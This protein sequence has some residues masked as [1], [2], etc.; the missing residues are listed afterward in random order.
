MNRRHSLPAEVYA[1]VEQTPATVLLE[2]RAQNYSEGNKKPW[3][4]LFTVPL[5]VCAAYSAA[6]VP[7][8]F[9]AIESAVAAGRCA[10]GFFTYECGTF[11][12]P[13]AT[14]HAPRA[15]QPLA[16]FG[17]YERGYAFDHDGGTFVD[18]EPPELERLRAGASRSTEPEA[19]IDADF[20]LTQPEYIRR[21]AAIH[22][23]IRAGDVYQLNFTAPFRVNAAGSP[24]ALYA[25]LRTRQPVD[26]G[27]FI[28]WE[29]GQHI[30]SFSP[31]LFF[32]I[33]SE[34][35]VRR[36]VTRPMKGTAQR[37]RTTLED[38]EIADWLRNDPKNR[39]ENV[40]I[41]DMLRNDLGRIA[42]FGTVRVEDL[43]AVERY[44]TLWQ[45]TSTVTGE[46]RPEIDFHGIFRA[47]FPSGSITGAPKVR[48]MQLLAELEGRPRGVYTGAIGFFSS[49]Q[50]IFNVAI[51]TLEL[52]EGRGVFGVG[53]GV[54]IDSNPADEF[55]ECQL[56]AE[57]LTGPAHRTKDRFFVSQPDELFLIETMLWNG[58][59]PFL[60]L[61]L[62]RLADSADYFGFACDRAAV[63]AALVQHAQQFSSDFPR[64]V[65][66]LMI[67]ADGSVQIGCDPLPNADPHYVGRVCIS[68]HR[69]DP[70]DAT[71]Y[72]KTTQR[73]IYAL[74][75]Q[76]ASAKGFDDVLFLNLR[77]EVTEGAISNVFIEKSGRWFTPP[78]KCGLLAGVYR[79]HL[80]ET[81]PE[82][83]E[84]VLTFDDLC[85]ADAIYLS[86]AVRGLRRVG[87]ETADP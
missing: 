64:K 29:R 2:G 52:C 84:R 46:L 81:R 77:G 83:E 11:F 1:L 23:W 54:V 56:K 62:D 68:S 48:A 21:I 57:F 43:F 60:E 9:A 32:R 73:P 5:R 67:D 55:R 41:V 17:I 75:Y 40:M 24:A 63:R 4:Q 28:H 12:E 6:E 74:A 13:K 25:R 45:M 27:A 78:V 16:W 44:P 10:A 86:N 34:G 49:R 50:T 38:R 76:Q 30:L 39:S 19:E 58:S 71:L 82:I 53:S 85:T 69:T 80:L 51:R 42:R 20:T 70:S 31:E 18:G 7:A 26:Y 66:L 8:C 87:L 59:Y 33:D 72:H 79:R 47:L 3:T 65:R 61:H 35:G 22:E 14:T 37:G 36:V 15:G